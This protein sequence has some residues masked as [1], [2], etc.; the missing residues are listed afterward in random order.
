MEI[1]TIT[2]GGVQITVSQPYAEGHTC[3]EAE[4]K[5]LNQTRAENIGNNMRKRI[6]EIMDSDDLSDD[7]K[8]EA[9]AEA[10]AEY[11][12]AYVFS[13][14]AVR[15][16]R[17][18]QSPLEKEARKVAREY[19]AEQLRAKGVTQKAYKEAKGDDAI[20]LLI[21]QLIENDKIKAIAQERIDAAA[22]KFA[23]LDLAV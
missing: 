8:S 11:D 14:V 9:I 16:S 18:S 2:S 6:G 3:T 12:A 23:D 19:I 13:M 22:N 21:E 5:A 10:V 7:Q 1:K 20:D 4:A 15:S 17:S